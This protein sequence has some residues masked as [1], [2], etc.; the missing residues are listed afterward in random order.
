MNF[1][2]LYHNEEL[3]ISLISMAFALGTILTRGSYKE[4]RLMVFNHFLVD[5]LVI[6]VRCFSSPVITPFGLQPS[7]KKILVLALVLFAAV[8][9]PAQESVTIKVDLSKPMGRFEPVWAWVGHDEPNY[10]YS[11]EG[12]NLLT[13][14][15]HLSSYP[16]HDRTHNLLTSGDGTATLKWGSTN[17]FTRDASG[18][19]LYDWTIIDRIFDAYET[20]GITP[21]VEIGFMPEALSVHPEPYQ[22]HWPQS[23]GTGWSYPPKNYQEWSN[24]LYEWVRHMADRYGAGAVVKW[25]WEVWNEPD[26]VYWHGTIDEYCKLYDY[27]VAAVKRALPNAR[28]GGP[29]TTGPGNQHAA[30][31]LRDFL[32]HCSTGQNYATGK[33]GAPLDFISFHAKGKAG[34]IDD[35]VEL[36]IA[37]NLKD[38]DQG[39]AIIEKFP[40]LRNLPVVLSESDP[41]GCAA[42]DATSHSENGYRLTSQYGSYEAELLNGTLCLAQRHHIKLEGA[43]SW[44]FTF[45][46]QPIFAGLRSFATQDI[47]LPVLNVFGLFGQLNGERVDAE[48]TGA[49]DLNEVVQSSVRKNSD[50]NAIATQDS[51]RVNVLVWNYH[52]DANQST[53]VEVHLKIAGLPQG[54]T[55]V[56]LEHLRVDHDH[57]NAYTAWQNMESP[58][59]PSALQHQHL[60]AAGQLQLLESPRFV[61]VAGNLVEFT[62]A[63]P[64][65]GVSLLNLTW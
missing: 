44:A 9:L 18:R 58:Q 64:T 31:F 3:K 4:S 10:T 22:Q 8:T 19:P 13:R 27:T 24:L 60:K 59:N 38:I 62:F 50:V 53:A 37:S 26:I 34:F 30:D 6:D 14:L 25:E 7:R 29:A 36:N 12:R 41:E 23:F 35:H 52:D 5:S 56:L 45:P 28:V 46:G 43:V 2:H 16:V 15:S 39:F 48:S 54:V 40:A 63:E 61:A 57:S 20:I 33:K 11:D 51:H 49:L 55:Q 1:D 47:D 21:F 65:Q 42:C 17:A 32:Q